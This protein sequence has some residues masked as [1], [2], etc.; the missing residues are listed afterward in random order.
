MKKLILLIGIFLMS[1]SVAHAET[2]ILWTVESAV[3]GDASMITGENL[4]GI[5]DLL[6][7]RLPDKDVTGIAPKYIR[8]VLP[9]E[10]ITNDTNKRKTDL[11]WNDAADI[12]VKIL[13]K[14]D[15]CI[16]FVI[17]ETVGYG[18]YAIKPSGASIEEAR[19]CNRPTI[20][21][22]QGDMGLKSTPDGWIR[23]CGRN[24]SAN[25]A[26]AM[27]VFENKSSGALTYVYP[28]KVFDAYSVEYKIPTYL[29]TGDYLVYAHNGYGGEAA[30]SLPHEYKIIEKP[31]WSS[32]VFNV[33]DYGAK[34][35]GVANDS[36][37]LYKTLEAVEKNGGGVVYFPRGRYYL[38]T[39]FRIP[40]YTTIK[41]A[42]KDQVQLF[43]TDDQWEFGSMPDALFSFSGNV[44]IEDLSMRGTRAY[45][46]IKSDKFEKAKGNVYLNN[47]YINFNPFNG[48]MMRTDPSYDTA[49]EIDSYNDGEFWVVDLGG[50]NV[51]V[52]NC[53]IAGGAGTLLYQATVG[54][55]ARNNT[56]KQGHAGFTG[57]AGNKQT[58]IED[59][60]LTMGHLNSSSMGVTTNMGV[61]SAEDYYFARNTEIDVNSNDRELWT[62]DGGRGYYYD[63]I[64]DYKDATVTLLEG[65]RFIENQYVDHDLIIAKGKGMGQYRTITSNTASTVTLSSPFAIEPDETSVIS[66]VKRFNNF[67]LVDNDFNRGGELQFYSTMMRGVMDGNNI[68]QS[69]GINSL[70]GMIY[71]GFQPAFYTLFTNNTISG[72]YHFHNDGLSYM[73]PDMVGNHAVLEPG[74]NLS[75]YAKFQLRT[76]AAGDV[77]HFATMIKNNTI[78]EC[79]YYS[80][81]DNNITNTTTTD[82]YSALIYDNNY[83]G[84]NDYGYKIDAAVRDVL[85]YRPKFHNIDKKYEFTKMAT[86]SRGI[87]VVE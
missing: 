14:S 28:S 17:P 50:E 12:S 18:V 47:L 11:V 32:K 13:H 49:K 1:V 77:S 66:I 85:I 9:G 5:E 79:G 41:G 54:S 26:K 58:I 8:T 67:L 33:K 3:P 39:A 72:G 73:N 75:G 48:G 51:N 31:V 69:G 29:K 42:S 57:F 83:V 22:L 37:A 65:T 86:D 80:L 76:Q 27:I 25:D 63:R 20:D 62:T 81:T 4:S 43:W 7:Y 59:N 70:S 36:Y 78:K 21:W 52:E 16:Q 38:T 56:L 19:F 35:N 71:N 60:M 55:V 46:I 2:N 64:L 40:E 23:V 53:Y 68:Y 84:E 82:T 44:R 6:I 24:L 45:S 87:K 74:D 61:V 15:S 30:W 10:Y 34:G